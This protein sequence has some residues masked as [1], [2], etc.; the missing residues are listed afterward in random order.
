LDNFWLI[1]IAKIKASLYSNVWILQKEVKLN[2]SCSHLLFMQ[3]MQN[4]WRLQ[5]TQGVA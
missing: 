5:A 3:V 1:N 4:W 2:A